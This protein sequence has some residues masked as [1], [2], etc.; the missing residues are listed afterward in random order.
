[1]TPQEEK[2]KRLQEEAKAYGDKLQAEY[3]KSVKALARIDYDKKAEAVADL[4]NEEQQKVLKMTPD[5]PALI[6]YGL[7]QN[8]SKAREL[9]KITDLAKF[10]KAVTKLEFIARSSR[11]KPP[12]PESIPRGSAHRNIG[13][14]T[15]G[16]QILEQCEKT[17]D[18]TKYAAYLKNKKEKQT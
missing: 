16:D 11:Q 15:R 3:S 12:P 5:N 14:D 1:M 10:V 9:A 18:Y 7:G 8:L 4:M 2:K 13:S 6:V 17:G